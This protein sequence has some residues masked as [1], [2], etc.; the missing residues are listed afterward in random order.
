[1][2]GQTQQQKGRWTRQS[3][4]GSIFSSMIDNQT[5][6]DD[7]FA[8]MEENRA[9]IE[10]FKKLMYK[11]Q[12]KRRE[13]VIAFLHHRHK[14]RG[15][16]ENDNKLIA[17]ECAQLLRKA[18]SILSSAENYQK[19]ILSTSNERLEIN[20]KDEVLGMQKD[21]VFLDKLYKYF[22]NSTDNQ[23]P[24]TKPFDLM[25]CLA[26]LDSI[27]I[28]APYHPIN[29]QRFFEEH[30]QCVRFLKKFISLSDLNNGRKPIM[31]TD[32]DGT[33]KDYCSQYATNLQPIYS[34]I[35]LST[36]CEK[37][38]RFTAVLTAGPL[39]GPGILDLTSMPKEGPIVF[40]G[41]WGREWWLG[42]KRVVDDNG[43][44]DEG[45]DAL[46]RLS[47]EMSGLLESQ[48]FSHFGLVGSGVQRKVD[49]LTLGVQT[50][51][52][53]IQPDLSAKYQEEVKER[54]HRVDPNRQFLHF[55]PST[56]LEVE[57]V[58]HSDG[59]VWNKANGVA[60]LVATIGDT[61]ETGR[62][63]I[64][65]D[66]HSDLPMVI[67][68]ISKNKKGAMALFVTSNAGL[69]NRVREILGDNSNCCFVSCPD[70]IHAAMLSIL[71]AEADQPLGNQVRKNSNPTPAHDLVNNEVET[72]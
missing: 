42:G 13:F 52:G 67:H 54:L 20:V 41:S 9:N 37:Y 14:G 32:W 11:V 15:V 48:E 40:G 23:G 69:Q 2:E 56:E 34:A 53:H 50:V 38:T 62:V 60:H 8:R 16:E 71:S 6:W 21:L 47:N 33:M 30:E 66:T 65:G 57:V 44:S 59:I 51:C 72:A 43:I 1:M 7:L 35:S 24:T 64:C 5:D 3:R 36:F 10:D 70:V 46:E 63:L 49:R 28:L 58:V 12:T 27:G 19:E 39:R 55:D 4:R 29:A 61:L 17:T 45:L 22:A 18:H 25:S 26:E 31:I 68:A